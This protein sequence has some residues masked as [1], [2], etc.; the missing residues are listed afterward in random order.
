MGREARRRRRSSVSGESS[1]EMRTRTVSKVT[2]ERYSEPL[3]RSSHP[4][5]TAED[6][7][8]DTEETDG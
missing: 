2:G 5:P 3:E 8:E 6:I 1:E 7:A 4:A